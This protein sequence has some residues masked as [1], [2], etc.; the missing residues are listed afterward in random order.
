MITATIFRHGGSQAV[1]L[2]KAVRF[3][4]S[5]VLIEKQGDDV[6][7]KP[8][9]AKKFRPFIEIARHRPCPS[10]S[11]GSIPISSNLPDTDIALESKYIFVRRVAGFPWP[12]V[13]AGAKDAGAG[14]RSK[15]ALRGSRRKWGWASRPRRHG[16]G[17][18]MAEGLGGNGL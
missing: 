4:G 14:A 3:D 15:R 8:V 17:G 18:Q 10:S 1:R 11:A 9:S 12:S 16:G 7:L 2:P 5:E 6:L 13:P